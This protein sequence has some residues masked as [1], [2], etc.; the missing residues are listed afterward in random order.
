MRGGMHEITFR[1]KR[2]H[3][4]AVAAGKELLGHIE[5]MTPARFDILCLLRQKAIRWGGGSN[6]NYLGQQDIERALDL[7]PSTIS[8]MLKRL[9]AM[10][11][12]TTER[13]E[14]NGDRRRKIVELTPRGLRCIWLAMRFL[15][16]QR[17]LLKEFEDIARELH[18]E[19]HVFETLEELDT[20]LDLIGRN[21]G[22]RSTFYYDW[23]SPDRAP[24]ALR[25]IEYT[26]K[27]IYRRPVCTR[28]ELPRTREAHRA[29]RA[30][31]QLANT[32]PAA[33]G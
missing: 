27:P 32:P 17:V 7:H 22:D 26:T 4:R 21:L 14:Y 18:P 25:R 1:L 15:W 5:G 24:Y 11:W 8:K 29:V 3:L 16:R 12:V 10:G 13:D 2:G 6:L 19:R 23:G 28:Y 33:A 20:S 30:L 9:V 31:T